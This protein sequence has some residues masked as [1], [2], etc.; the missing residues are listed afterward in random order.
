MVHLILSRAEEIKQTHT[1][2][3]LVTLSNETSLARALCHPAVTDEI[4]KDLLNKNDL[5]NEKQ[6]L[7]AFDMVA[8]YGGH[9]EK[10]LEY[11]KPLINWLENHGHQATLSQLPHLFCRHD[12]VSL[13]KWF[14]KVNTDK[15]RRDLI[16]SVF[17]SS[18]T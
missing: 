7:V 13:L 10:P 11:L 9:T 18:K 8:R 1:L 16:Y 12:N 2:I 3:G 14:N 15:V 17:L 4:I 5:I 6:L